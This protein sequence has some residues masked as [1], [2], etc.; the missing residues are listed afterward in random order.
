M[1]CGG[2]IYFAMSP[3]ATQ[4]KAIGPDSHKGFMIEAQVMVGK[5][6]G[7]NQKC[8]LGN[9]QKMFGKNLHN[10]GYDSIEFNPGDGTELVVYCSSQVISAKAIPWKC[11]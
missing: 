8:V 4:T 1:W 7:G 11:S 3:E 9:G 10:A 2:G 5:V 6:A